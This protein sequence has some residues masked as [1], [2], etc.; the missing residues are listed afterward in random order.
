MHGRSLSIRPRD[1]GTGQIAVWYFCLITA[2]C[3][4]TPAAFL[5]RNHLM[6]L[7]ECFWKATIGVVVA[8]RFSRA[9]PAPLI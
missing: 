5:L 6:L 8:F 4:S 9:R 2:K 1:D 3:K 7:A